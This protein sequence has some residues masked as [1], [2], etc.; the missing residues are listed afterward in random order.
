[1]GL[2]YWELMSHPDPTVLPVGTLHPLEWFW[3]SRR[4]FIYSHHNTFVLFSEMSIRPAFR[5]RSVA[6]TVMLG[7]ISYLYNLSSNIRRCVV[8]KVSCNISKFEFLAFFLNCNFDLVFF[9]FGIS[10]ESLVW[11]IVGRQG[12]SQN[13]GVLVVLV[14]FYDIVLYNLIFLYKTGLIWWIFSQ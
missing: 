2:L 8:C 4:I 10:C 7:S 6:P 3:I 1:M 13:A 11:V 5:V 12:V 9:S 14:S